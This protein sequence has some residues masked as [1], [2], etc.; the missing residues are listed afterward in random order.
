MEKSN[1]SR[2]LWNDVSE[3]RGN[4]INL[5]QAGWNKCQPESSYAHYRD[6]YI[7]HVIKSGTGIIEHGGHR[8][9]LGKNEVFLIKPGELTV[10]T[11]DAKDPWELYYFS[12]KGA[13][14][15]EFLKKTVF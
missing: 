12:F 15:E 7:I 13:L 10:Q 1:L 14:A 4:Y 2:F 5:V 3:E 11:A 9:S 8:Y 6:M